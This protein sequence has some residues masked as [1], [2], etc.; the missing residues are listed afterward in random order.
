MAAD[1]R[2]DAFFTRHGVERRF[3]AG[4]RIIRAGEDAGGVYFV[5]SGAVKVVLVGRSGRESVLE[6]RES[7]AL[8]GEMSVIL[9]RAR[10]AAVDGLH[11]GVLLLVST[12]RFRDGLADAGFAGAVLRET[13]RRL[14]QASVHQ[15]E[16]AAGDARA[17]VARV[18]VDLADR[19]G[20]PAA[21]GLLVRAITQKDLADFA[22]VSRDGVVRSFSDFR[23]RGWLSTSRRSIILHDLD[24]LRL[25]SEI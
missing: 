8:V 5:R 4:E 1:G 23:A 21:V 12:A 6:I 14:G 2:I 13:V 22:G 15:H 17:R 25:A 9:G 16:I 20:E 24:A 3:A 7:G 10:S 19:V 18:I 11:N